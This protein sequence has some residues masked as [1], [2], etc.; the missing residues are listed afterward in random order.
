[1]CS[2]DLESPS[3]AFEKALKGI[4]LLADAVKQ[5]LG[6]SGRNFLIEK[7]GGRITNDGISIAREI[8]AKDEVEDIALRI[9]REAAIKT[10]EDAGDGTTTATTLAQAIIHECYEYMPKGT[11]LGKRSVMD[12]RRQIEKE[13]KQA[14]EELIK[15]ATPVET[16]GELINIAR[17]SVEDTDLAELIGTAQWDLGRQG[18]IIVEENPEPVITIER[19]QGIRIDNGL[20]TSMVMNDPERQRLV[21]ENVPVILTNHTL[22]TLAPLASL[23]QGLV[24][25]GKT[26]VVIVAR[27]YSSE[28][29]QQIMENHKRG[30]MLYPMQAPYVNQREIFKDLE[31]SLDSRYIHDEEASLESLKV[32]E[33]GIAQKVVGYRYSAEFIGNNANVEK[34]QA[35][36]AHIKKELEGEPSKF[37]RRALE[38]RIA[39]MEHG[40]AVL[41][42]G[43]LSDVDRKY[44]VDKA[45]DAVNAVRSAFQE[46]TVRGAG[47]ALMEVA[48]VLG[49]DTLLYKPLKR[50][51]EQI[52]ENA[53]GIFEVE[54]WVRNSLKVDR[55]ALLNACRIAADMVTIGG[56]VATEKVKPL[57]E[58]LTKHD[59]RTENQEGTD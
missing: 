27:A 10:N 2:S 35:R 43:S 13:A 56:V 37:Q 8:Q 4:D 7:S 28:C 21:A 59:T 15:L 38:E 32:H 53:G 57:Q 54:E 12:L 16:K 55:Y 41:K 50:P 46:G 42:I 48:E 19:V 24:T 36:V 29:I 51:Y 45:E 58:L 31:A 6:P 1:V 18:R 34:V 26:S 20:G 49:K 17:V 30:I 25:Q 40:F 23:L 5:T 52:M 11:Q 44:K 22:T 3:R 47:I 14:E 9:F 39:Q 33:I